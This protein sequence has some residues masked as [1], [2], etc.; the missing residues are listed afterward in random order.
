MKLVHINT[1][2][3][4][5]LKLYKVLFNTISSKQMFRPVWGK[6]PNEQLFVTEIFFGISLTLGKMYTF[7]RGTDN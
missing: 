3:L 5:H 7:V 6:G 4:L 2:I 1:V